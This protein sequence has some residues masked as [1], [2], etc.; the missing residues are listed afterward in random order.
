MKKFAIASFLL[1]PLFVFSFVSA[2]LTDT[3]DQST[4]GGCVNLTKNMSVG[5]KDS[6]TN[7]QVSDLQ[8]FLNDKGYLKTDPT[9][10]FGA[11]TLAAVKAFQ[12]DNGITPNGV[13][14]PITRGKIQDVSCSEGDEPGTLN[15][16]DPLPPQTLNGLS[17]SLSFEG[18]AGNGASV[19][20]TNGMTVT[21]VDPMA[22]R[23]WKWSSTGVAY[24]SA[25]YSITSTNPSVKICQWATNGYTAWSPWDGSSV[26]GNRF[27]GSNSRV[28]G[29]TYYG[30]TIEAKYKGAN[31]S[32]AVVSSSVKVVMLDQ[33]SGLSSVT[34]CSNGLVMS[35]CPTTNNP[36]QTVVAITSISVSSA[37]ISSPVGVYGSGFT[38]TGNKVYLKKV[39]GS[40]MLVGTYTANMA[41]ES[42]SQYLSFSI[43]SVWTPV[44]YVCNGSCQQQVLVPG[45][46]QV[47]VVNTNGTS[48]PV[49]L[50]ITAQGAQSFVA[51]VPVSSFSDCNVA[52]SNM[53]GSYGSDGKQYCYRGS[54]GCP[55]GWVESRLS[56]T[57]SEVKCNKPT[58]AGSCPSNATASVINGTTQC[59]CAA[60]NTYYGGSC[61][62]VNSPTVPQCPGYYI[63]NTSGVCV[64]SLH[65]ASWSGTQCNQTG[66]TT[67]CPL[68]YIVAETGA[69]AYCV[70]D[71]SV[72]IGE[73]GT[74]AGSNINIPNKPGLVCANSATSFGSS[75]TANVYTRDNSGNLTLTETCKG[76]E[77]KIAGVSQRGIQCQTNAQGVGAT[78][79]SQ[80]S[81]F[82]NGQSV[83]WVGNTS[84]D[85]YSDSACDNGYSCNT[86]KKCAPMVQVSYPPY[87]SQSD[88]ASLPA[89]ATSTVY[90]RTWAGS[91]WGAWVS[92]GCIPGLHKEGGACVSDRKACTLNNAA[93]VQYYN[94]TTNQWGTCQYADTNANGSPQCNPGYH[95]QSQG[96]YA[97]DGSGTVG[98][99]ANVKSC[100]PSN[101]YPTQY[102][103]GSNVATGEQRWENNWGIPSWGSC[104]I[105]CKAGFTKQTTYSEDGTNSFNLG[106][107]VSSNAIDYCTPSAGVYPTGEISFISSSGNIKTSNDT[108]SCIIPVGGSS[109]SLTVGWT[110]QNAQSAILMD[111][112]SSGSV[113]LG[114]G[115][116]GSA[117]VISNLVPT[118]PGVSSPTS[119]AVRLQMEPGGVRKQYFVGAVCASGSTWNGSSC[120]AGQQQT[121]SC[122]GTLQTGAKVYQ[123]DADGLTSSISYTYSS[124]DT[125]SKCQFY[126]DA[127]AGYSWNG[128]SCQL[129]ASGGAQPSISIS[130]PAGSTSQG[131]EFVVSV[132]TLHVQS[133]SCKVEYSTGGAWITHHSG[134]TSGSQTI[135]SQLPVGT[136]SLRASCLGVDGSTTY[137]STVVTHTVTQAVTNQA[138]ILLSTPS[139]PT[140]YG[141]S[142]SLSLTT[143]GVQANSCNVDYST[144]GGSSWIPWYTNVSGGTITTSPDLAVGTYKLRAECLNTSGQ[145]VSSQ[146]ASHEVL[147]PQPF[148]AV[149]FSSYNFSKATPV[150]ATISSSGMSKVSHSTTGASPSV[151]FSGDFTTV[152]GTQDFP[153]NYFEP[154]TYTP[155]L[156]GTPVSGGTQVTCKW[157]GQPFKVTQ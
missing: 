49:A 87:L 151:S 103:R 53:I 55:S 58:T 93:G 138:S 7:G 80:G 13:V 96:T 40:S 75:A 95:Y 42:N 35:P 115:L 97:Q 20:A 31:T 100:T 66:N 28:F 143:S 133:N 102:P 63:R 32:G 36:N 2:Q 18:K 88:L 129:G 5:A 127:G 98:C 109:C 78:C 34:T 119:H 90:K 124:S 144:N 110:T 150:T 132:D 43:P 52:G 29:A 134:F 16:T 68:G 154:N 4:T 148:C 73:T 92:Q 10:Y 21:N 12:S 123:G 33:G 6:T 38:S 145:K 118:S 105:K 156:K 86:N 85:C 113:T 76:N 46:Y 155:I 104:E 23:T 136:Y 1:A 54:M 135:G 3:I 141:T 117:K 26:T 9:G 153:A 99:V 37:S 126:C 65:C 11:A 147:A 107:W 51:A 67:S 111:M 47:Y 84:G 14:G 74:P 128:S 81:V 114:E 152:N 30:C 108:A 44:E 149:T 64:M 41:I 131:T 83:R 61:V 56:S 27:N 101:N 70:I 17:S 77:G 91:A 79:S 142:F 116:Q 22:L 146:I 137:T 94:T 72:T 48:S 120:V 24:V 82:I 57:D 62:A 15:P 89:D 139:A 112:P 69:S 45:N 19:V 121:Y 59:S 130:V 106:S 125:S 157:S 25:M 50:T 71:T 60:G 39:G 8:F 140:T 122:Q